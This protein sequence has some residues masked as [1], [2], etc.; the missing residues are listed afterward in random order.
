MA[1]TLFP[2]LSEWIFLRRKTHL[3]ESSLTSESYVA[4][5][6]GSWEI[7]HRKYVWQI[8]E[9]IIN[10]FFFVFSLLFFNHVD[11]IQHSLVFS[12]SKDKK[13]FHF[14]EILNVMR[15]H[16]YFKSWEKAKMVLCCFCVIKGKNGFALTLFP[17]FGQ[18]AKSSPGH[19][20]N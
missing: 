20:K 17:S 18:I 13:T 2:S 19:I 16:R 8:K 1:I 5:C 12:Q 3:K 7:I 6:L 11:F 14:K 9:Q 4:T 10:A 15:F